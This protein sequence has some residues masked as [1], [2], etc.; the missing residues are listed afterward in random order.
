MITRAL[1]LA[2][3][4]VS[5]AACGGQ[6]EA[7]N[8]PQP[9]P[10]TA[11]T[12]EPAG[13]LRSAAI[14]R[15]QERLVQRGYPL[16]PTGRLDQNTRRALLGF[17]RNHNLVP[18]GMPSIGTLEALELNPRDFYSREEARDTRPWWMQ[19]PTANEDRR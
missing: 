15:L 11:G 1:I 10:V 18:T 6:Q 16:T 3:L 7:S 13:L 12:S 2:L 4:V 8:P 19:Q 9:E 14:Q 5:M 17:Q